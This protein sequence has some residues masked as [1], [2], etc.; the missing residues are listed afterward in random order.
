M[1]RACHL[2]KCFL[3]FM[4]IIAQSTSLILL[5]IPGISCP[6]CL[7][8]SRKFLT[9]SLTSPSSVNT[10]PPEPKLF[11]FFVGSKLNTLISPILPLGTPLKLAPKLCAASSIT[12]T[13][14]LPKNSV[15]ILNLSQST[16]LP[17]KLAYITVLISE[18][19]AHSA[20]PK[21]IRPLASTSQICISA[22]LDS[23]AEFMVAI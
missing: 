4:V 6:V 14:S 2:S 10:I 23:I 7:P 15:I 13:R 19:I 5:L 9:N 3:S 22:Y 16:V 11:K 12:L 1:R 21:S 20:L 17:N 8:L 18:P